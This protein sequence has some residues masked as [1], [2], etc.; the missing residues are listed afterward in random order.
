MTNFAFGWSA[1]LVNHLRPLM[2]YCMPSRRMDVCRFVGSEDAVSGSVMPIH[3]RIWPSS[4]GISQC[5]LCCFVAK[6]C[7]SSMFPVSGALQLKPSEHPGQAAHHFRKGGILKIAE[8]R[9][10]LVLTQPW[11]EQ[12]PEP[13]AFGTIL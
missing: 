10:R 1:P 9:A 2:M 3:D 11:Q 12:I 6:R 13:L 7:R 8:P 4:S 5:S